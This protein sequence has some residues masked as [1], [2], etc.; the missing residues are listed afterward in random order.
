VKKVLFYVLIC[1][2]IKLVLSNNYFKNIFT[3]IF[4]GRDYCKLINN[5]ILYLN[6]FGGTSNKKFY[7]SKKES[8]EGSKK[9]KEA[10]IA[11][12]QKT[13]PTLSRRGFLFFIC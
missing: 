1:E 5:L 9:G 2:I 4:L 7:G 11:S 8:K 13:S 12:S 3:K 10:S 6:H